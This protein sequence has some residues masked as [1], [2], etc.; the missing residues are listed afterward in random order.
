MNKCKLCQQREADKKGSHVV[1][2]FLLREV[3]NID[4]KKERNYEIGFSLGGFNINSYFGSSILPK[5]LEET[6]G[7]IQDKDIQ[8]NSHPMIIDHLLCTSCEKRFS[9]LESFYAKSLG[10]ISEEVIINSNISYLFWIS[11]FWRLS[12]VGNNELHLPNDICEYYRDL[13]DRSLTEEK[14]RRYTVD[15]DYDL[16]LL[17]ITDV[18]K[19]IFTYPFFSDG[20][21]G[22]VVGSNIALIVIDGRH[23]EIENIVLKEIV[24]LMD[25]QKVN[26]KGNDNE[27][28]I[29]INNVQYQP[30]KHAIINDLVGDHIYQFS[31]VVNSLID[32]N[33]NSTST[34]KDQ[35]KSEIIKKYRD[36][37]S[38][39]VGRRYTSEHK[40][41]CIIDTLIEFKV[42]QIIDK[43][44]M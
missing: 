5:R 7:E 17:K 22:L 3:E 11:V 35:L 24:N 27:K 39:P 38:I 21:V 43:S 2:F 19:E 1:P 6:F 9:A 28:R 32:K 4:G 44:S 37:D 16:Y 26:K 10:D 33:I 12:V 29:L 25:N 23:N 31:K 40:K 20:I 15:E 14:D 8:E 13:L 18:D 36:N 34:I 41:S 30:I 42:L